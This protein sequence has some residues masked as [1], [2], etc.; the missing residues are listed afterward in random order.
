[1]IAALSVLLL[2]VAVPVSAQ[3]RPDVRVLVMPFVVQ[4]D[5]P[6]AASVTA[7]G[8]LGEAAAILITDALDARGVDV[9]TRDERASAF[10]R[11]QLPTSATLT[12][13]TTIRTAELLGA[14]DVVVGEVKAGKTLSVDSRVIR[15]DLAEQS[16][17]VSDQAAPETMFSLFDRTAGRLIEAAGWRATR[18]QSALPQPPSI[19][20]FENYV[21]GLI[22]ATPMLQQRWLEMAYR[23][24]PRDPRVLLA[25]S[26]VYGDQGQHA[27]AL[28]AARNV[29]AESPFSRKARFAAALSLVE[30]GRFDEATRELTSL[31]TERASPVLWNMLGVVQLRRPDAKDGVAVELFTHAVNIDR[32]DPDYLFNLGYA[33]AH[34]RDATMALH[35]LREAV[36]FDATSGDAHLVMSIVLETTGRHPEAQRELEL[37]K[38]LGTRTIV[39]GSSPVDKLPARLERVRT[40][41]DLPRARRVDLALSAPAEQDQQQF[42]AFHL[43]EGKRFLAAGRDRDA[44]NALRRAIYL[45]PYED[46]PH[47][48]LGRL[49]ARAGRLPEA[50]DEFKVAIWCR[51]T[52]EARLA[53]GAALFDN[54]DKLAARAEVLRALALRPGWKEA[55][56]LLGKINR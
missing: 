50:I 33:Y 21:R 1:V 12:R 19:S 52:A 7:S 17:P 38:L 35:W 56:D 8:W 3:S 37:A 49:Y 5:S 36:R 40:D 20:V 23:E 24:A 6:S 32:D 28:A 18:V 13:A 15:L 30:L 48:L 51:E 34:G 11:L 53:L 2:L 9:I 29:P 42:A 41:L 55:E 26:S 31:N 46:E 10:D 4:A 47:L 44:A 54:A 25:L 16:P 39:S 27:R 22:A 45:A 43:A 14:S